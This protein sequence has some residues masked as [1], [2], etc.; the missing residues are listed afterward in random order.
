MKAVLAL[1]VA[2]FLLVGVNSFAGVVLD[3]RDADVVR[4]E[5]ILEGVRDFTIPAMER[6]F[7]KFAQYAE[8]HREFIVDARELGER[9]VL[10][11]EQGNKLL[12][13]SKNQGVVYTHTE[14]KKLYKLIYAA[15]EPMFR[16]MRAV[17]SGQYP[18]K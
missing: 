16:M 6:W 13:M 12:E 11:K 5:G 4:A 8:S 15:N 17:H 3:K 18:L 14:F 2:C 7:I 10:I 9:I 1:A